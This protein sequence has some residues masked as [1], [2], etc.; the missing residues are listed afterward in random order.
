[1]VNTTLLI[2]ETNV[3]KYVP[4]DENLYGG[5]LSIAIYTAQERY[6]PEV[7][8]GCLYRTLQEK[9]YDGSISNEEN[10]VYKNL[11]D[12]IAP[13]LA[14]M[15]GAE[16]IMMTY[17]KVANLSV[18]RMTD[19][20]VNFISNEEMNSLRD[21]YTNRAAIYRETVIKFLRENSSF[22]PELQNCSCD[23]GP[24][25][26]LGECSIFLGGPRNPSKKYLK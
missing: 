6:M 17:I 25:Y 4:L 16:A 12:T 26:T 22:L 5:Y 13:Y 24:Q 15:A 18:A 9:I 7:L 11:L 2:S 20:G 1:M 21:E 3:K 8:G 10:T 14:W 23:S 19:T